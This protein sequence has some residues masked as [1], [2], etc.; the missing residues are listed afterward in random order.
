MKA[1]A[2]IL[3]PLGPMLLEETDGALTRLSFCGGSP[4]G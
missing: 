3:S 1:A 2:V 4:Y